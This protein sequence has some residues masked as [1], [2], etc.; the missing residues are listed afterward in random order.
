MSSNSEWPEAAPD[1]ATVLS[2]PEAPP[3]S[4]ETVSNTVFGTAVEN[5]VWGGWDVFKIGLLMFVAPYLVIPITALIAQ[6]TIYRG[7]PWLTVAQ[8]PGI[9]LSTQ[10]GWYVLV[11]IYMVMF[12]EGQF[13]QDFWNS[14]RWNW[15]RR[16]WPTLVPI[17]MILV[18][19]Q[20]LER[21]FRL[22]KHVPMEE[23]LSTPSLAVLMGLFAVSFGP[24]ME[25]LFFRGFLYPVLTKRFGMLAGI[26]AT[27]V[28][29]GL[30]HAAQLAFAWGLVLII[31][32]VGTVLTIVRAKTGSVG[33]S[34]VVHVAYNSTLVM[35]GALASHHG[36]KIAK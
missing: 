3:L 8:K 34:F 26:V 17:G 7:L 31:F 20:A 5:P 16:Y 9:A 29:F 32:L 4:A 35:L 15:P 22:P 10:L 6:K 14:I 19:L 21:F 36:D 24:L 23:F 1:P 33:A 2:S 30:I 25:E 28:L 12:V 13:H 27:S 18:S 11:A